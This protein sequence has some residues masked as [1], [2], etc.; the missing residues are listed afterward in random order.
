M[1][2]NECPAGTYGSPGDCDHTLLPSVPPADT[3]PPIDNLVNTGFDWTWL[4]PAASVLIA[5]GICI[6]VFHRNR[7]RQ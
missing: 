4:I 6:Y 7:A 1:S 5:V 2:P 3:V